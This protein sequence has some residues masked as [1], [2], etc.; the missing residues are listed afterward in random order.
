VP[1]QK[2]GGAFSVK[3]LF[4]K[5]NKKTSTLYKANPSFLLTVNVRQL[6][7]KKQKETQTKN[8]TLKS[9]TLKTLTTL[10]LAASSLFAGSAL[11]NN[12]QD[13]GWVQTHTA[14]ETHL[15]SRHLYCD[16][17]DL[18]SAK[19]ECDAHAE[20]N[21]LNFRVS[22]HTVCFKAAGTNANGEA[23]PEYHATGT[24]YDVLVKNPEQDSAEQEVDAAS[25]CGE[26]MG[27][28]SDAELCII[29]PECTTAK[30]QC[31]MTHTLVVQENYRLKARV[32]ELDQRQLRTTHWSG[33]VEYENKDACR[34]QTIGP[35]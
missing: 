9:L 6:S 33:G 11:A 5:T 19:A 35:S 28:D 12:A 15:N 20:C 2:H 30:A 4:L 18:E 1:N 25:Y 17:M 29:Q 8:I 27:W 24:G 10:A 16:Y 31:D 26:H 23:L 34:R 3:P 13:N 22:D 21:G 32:A 7:P 14:Q